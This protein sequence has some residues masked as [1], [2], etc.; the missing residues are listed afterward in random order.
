MADI[1]SHPRD[2]GLIAVKAALKDGQTVARTRQSGLE[3]EL[4]RQGV[5]LSTVL[6]RKGAG[7]LALRLPLFDADAAC[8]VND[9]GDRLEQTVDGIA[10]RVR[11]VLERDDFGPEQFRLTLRAEPH[12]PLVLKELGR[13]WSIA[14][15][16][17]SAFEMH[18]S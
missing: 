3:I 16:R 14:P 15:V 1:D 12:Q 11:M 8:E 7:G 10:A 2:A 4:R 9:T 17:T 18:R 13:R 6:R 5:D